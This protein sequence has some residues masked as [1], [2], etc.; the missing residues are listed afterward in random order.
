[1]SDEV[2]TKREILSL[3]ARVAALTTFSYITMKWL[4]DALDPTAKQQAQAQEKAKKLMKNLGIKNDDVKLTK[5]ELMVA[6]NLVEPASMCHKWQD[7]AGLDS[8]VQELRDTVILPIQKRELFAESQLTQPPKGVLLHGPPGC[9]KT[10]IAQATAGEAQARF[11]NLDVSLLTDK[12]YGESQK[13]A[14]AVFTLARKIAPCIIFVDEIDS[15]LRSRDTHDHEATAMIKAQFMQ[16][17]DGLETSSESVVVMGATNRP[18]DVDRAILRRMPATFHIGLPDERQRNSI[19]RRVLGMERIHEDLDFSRLAKLTEG[20]S[21]SDIR[22]ACRTASVYRMREHGSLTDEDKRDCIKSVLPDSDPSSKTD[23]LNS[24][25]GDH[26]NEV[27]NNLR[28]ITND[29]LLKA[30]G[31]LRESKLHCGFIAPKF[32][33]VGGLD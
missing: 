7:I 3:I 6:S 2:I 8:V 1:M 25:S 29:D 14:S 23:A 9:G 19:F 33:G 22:E 16:M 27:Q 10:M 17:W 4:I 28:S 20:F 12:W 32:S 26:K 30:V 18:R 11:I 13:L 21:G 31:K 24:S 5:H 15:L